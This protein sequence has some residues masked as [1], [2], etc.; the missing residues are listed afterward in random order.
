MPYQISIFKILAIIL[1]FGCERKFCQRSQRTLPVTM[2]VLILA[3]RSLWMAGFVS[4][5]SLFCRTI[6]PRNVMLNSTLS[7]KWQIYCIYIQFHN[8]LLINL[9]RRKME[10]F[11][12][13]TVMTHSICIFFTQIFF[14]LDAMSAWDPFF[15]GPMQ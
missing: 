15:Y 13:S 3:S 6:I 12:Q 5:L 1:I 11:Y 4:G 7:L 14:E 10:Y 9:S 2:T 8:K